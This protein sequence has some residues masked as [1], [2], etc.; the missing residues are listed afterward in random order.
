[1]KD[2]RVI[3][4]FG[5]VR[6]Y[7]KKDLS[8]RSMTIEE[9]LAKGENYARKYVDK[10]YIW[11]EPDWLELYKNGADKENLYYI[12]CVRDKLAAKPRYMLGE[13]INIEDLKKYA[14]VVEEIANYSQ[15]VIT[16]GV[17]IISLR[18]FISEYPRVQL[19]LWLA[20]NLNTLTL[21]REKVSDAC[22]LMGFPENMVGRLKSAYLQKVRR[23]GENVGYKLLQKTA[24]GVVDLAPNK[25]FKTKEEAYGYSVEKLVGDLKGSRKLQGSTVVGYRC[26]TLE[27]A[28][29]MGPDLRKGV[30]ADKD[31]FR[32]I[33]RV[34]GMEFGKWVTQP[35][36]KTMLNYIYDAVSDLSAVL[37]VPRDVL[38]LKARTSI[39]YT[40][41]SRGYEKC[42]PVAYNVNTD[43][44]N[45]S[46]VD[47]AGYFASAY[48]EALDAYAGSLVNRENKISIV[49]LTASNRNA[50]RLKE[51][52]PTLY[53][54][55][56]KMLNKIR[57]KKNE[58]INKYT[59]F[60][61]KMMQLNPRVNILFMYK[62]CFAGYVYD[63]LKEMGIS[64]QFLVFDVEGYST[65]VYYPQGEER[66]E[67]NKAIEDFISTVFTF[68]GTRRGQHKEYKVP[69]T[70]YVSYSNSYTE[71]EEYE[72][73]T[74]KIRRGQL[75]LKRRLIA[76]LPVVQE[77][78]ELKEFSQR[79]KAIAK[80]K[81]LTVYSVPLDRLMIRRQ[82]RSNGFVYNPEKKVVSVEI[83]ENERKELVSTV[84]GV[85]YG[86][87]QKQTGTEPTE[88]QK[89]YV[90]CATAV[91]IHTV[92]YS[93]FRQLCMNNLYRTIEKD[94]YMSSLLV[95]A[96][97]EL[98]DILREREE[99]QQN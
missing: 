15:E 29:R 40:F 64:N 23:L 85:F 51:L 33:A 41:G 4:D 21:D 59:D 84:E 65:S 37:R 3:E 14:K 26:P 2:N 93:V 62:Q 76:I 60:Y 72:L 67:I 99:E 92:G 57:Y 30:N 96:V 27:R 82:G 19:P 48:A 6:G 35:E 58:G 74:A 98:I 7:G 61:H 73:Q 49:K 42:E 10:K 32:N 95:D 94:P 56:D 75:S 43:A 1:M 83:T 90:A 5:N 77:N 55:V 78:V 52:N 18:E 68:T 17:G 50:N 46:R 88:V 47:N 28:D 91:V 53:R 20:K 45:I 86:L 97:Q 25:V 80:T 38:G 66:K 44:I 34:D 63:K 70:E 13:P 54:A 11:E 9:I 89:L 22:N 8:Y 16:G 71:D 87:M 79:I 12:K 36:R 81:G 39:C 24:L 31:A 69:E